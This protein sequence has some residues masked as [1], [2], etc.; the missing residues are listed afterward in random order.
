VNATGPVWDDHVVLTRSPKR[1]CNR[2]VRRARR[3][4]AHRFPVR[5]S[6]LL[7]YGAV[8]IDPVHLVVWVLLAGDPSGLPAWYFPDGRQSQDARYFASLLAQIDA[9]REVVVASF[10]RRE[11]WP[12]AEHTHVGFDSDVR[13]GARGGWHYFK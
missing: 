12:D 8:D 13:V 11:G 9:M 4:L 6:S 10:A 1:R 3:E 2:A 7:W 5:F